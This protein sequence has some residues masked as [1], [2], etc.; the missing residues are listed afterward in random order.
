MRSSDDI[1]ALILRAARV[2]RQCRVE[3]HCEE[4]SKCPDLL[5][6]VVRQWFRE[7]SRTT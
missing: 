6:P 7:K 4:R 1:R 2:S 3:K 5:R